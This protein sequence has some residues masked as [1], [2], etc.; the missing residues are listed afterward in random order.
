MCSVNINMHT[1]IINTLGTMHVWN[2][3]ILWWYTYIPNFLANNSSLLSSNA[4]MKNLYFSFIF[5]A[6][7]GNITS[8]NMNFIPS[9]SF[10][11]LCSAILFCSSVTAFLANNDDSKALKLLSFSLDSST[12]WALSLAL[13]TSQSN[14][15]AWNK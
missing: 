13:A 14:F 2:F 9:R 5:C 1:A 10:F 4:L 7:L 6:R 15:A 11:C 8:S 12:Y 3:I